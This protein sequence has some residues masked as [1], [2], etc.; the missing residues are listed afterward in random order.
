M[1]DTAHRELTEEHGLSI[2]NWTMGWVGN[3][4][5]PIAIVVVNSRGEVV[6]QAGDMRYLLEARERA[7]AALAPDFD[8]EANPGGRTISCHSDTWGALGVAG[9]PGKHDPSGTDG[10]YEAHDFE[11][12]RAAW[13]QFV[14]PGCE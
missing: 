6:Q 3:P 13:T 10:R 7:Q 14:S 4:E 11:I 5:H 9:R 12:A 1:P 8:P 2:V